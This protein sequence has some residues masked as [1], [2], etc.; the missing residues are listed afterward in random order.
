MNDNAY[1]E[2]GDLSRF[3]ASPDGIVVHTN[4]TLVCRDCAFRRRPVGSCEK[5]SVRKPKAVLKGAPSCVYYEKDDTP[6]EWEM[7]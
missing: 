3:E 6:R 2:A 1:S 4:E 7:D 5:Y